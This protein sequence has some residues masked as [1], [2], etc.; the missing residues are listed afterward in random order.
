MFLLRLDLELEGVEV[1]RALTSR[2]GDSAG[3][4][5]VHIHKKLCVVSLAKRL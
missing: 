4:S 5:W 2:S 3:L 1:G